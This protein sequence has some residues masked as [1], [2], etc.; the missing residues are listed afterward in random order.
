VRENSSDR[1][2][3]E[4]WAAASEDKPMCS[5]HGCR[6]KGKALLTFRRPQEHRDLQQEMFSPPL[7]TLKRGLGRGVSLLHPFQLLKYIACT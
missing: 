1:G 5:S 2:V 7:P 6:N 3:A 4:S